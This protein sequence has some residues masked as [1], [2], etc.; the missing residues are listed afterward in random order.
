MMLWFIDPRCM[1]P[2]H[3]ANV[4][5]LMRLGAV[6][7]VCRVLLCVGAA[8]TAV[9]TGVAPGAFADPADREARAYT[10]EEVTQRV[11]DAQNAANAAAQRFTD[12]QSRFEQL[13]D[14]IA[15]V[16]Q[17]IEVGEYRAANLR[18]ITQRR[19]LLA[20]KTT[21][22][23]MSVLLHADSPRQGARSSVLLEAANAADNSAAKEYAELADEL[24]AK[25]AQL[26][27]ERGVQ[28]E[29]LNRMTEERGLLDLALADAE[30][31]VSDLAAKAQAAI[32]AAPG[33]FPVTSVNAPVI[34]GKVCPVPGAAFSDDFG[35]PRA[36]H[37]HQGNDM[38]APAGTSNLAI[39]SGNVTYGPGGSGGN[40]AYLEGDDGVT[41]VYY[42]L[43]EYVGGPRRVTQ[44]EVIAKLGSTGNASAPHTHFEMRPGGRSAN[45]IN[46]F[47][48]LDR[49]C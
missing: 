27:H 14:Q 45:A 7:A 43:A 10:V 24:A 11:V 8:A 20:Y 6:R 46:P 30:R 2:G 25:R 26:T 9:T 16:E 47:P 28:E 33:A 49:I 21:G 13:G 17:E 19:A 29:A 4:L 31:A 48:T 36:G 3:L 37:S 41:Y 1:K 42:H 23:D 5:H 40:G 44:G 22:A 39:V 12:A 32:E 18:E 38:F 15:A 34:D 35:D